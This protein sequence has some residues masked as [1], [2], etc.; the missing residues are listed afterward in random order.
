MN[1]DAGGGSSL[2]A[3]R[4][5]ECVGNGQVVVHPGHSKVGVL[6]PEHGADPTV[7]DYPR[8]SRHQLPSAMS[9][10]RDDFQR[11]HLPLNRQSAVLRNFQIAC[12]VYQRFGGNRIPLRVVKIDGWTARGNGRVKRAEAVTAR[13]CLLVQEHQM[14]DPRPV[15]EMGK[16]QN[17][18]PVAASCSVHRRHRQCV[19][20]APDGI[21]LHGDG[22]EPSFSVRRAAH[23]PHEV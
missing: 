11:L 21:D 17:C 2:L 7:R 1:R 5:E 18:L 8:R 20:D 12:D 19:E 9:R 13:L 14:G 23:R 3:A 15:S 6:E 16:I 10:N 4:R 22:G